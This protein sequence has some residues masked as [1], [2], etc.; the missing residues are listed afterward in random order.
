MERS[1][2]WVFFEKIIPKN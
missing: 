2:D 1:I